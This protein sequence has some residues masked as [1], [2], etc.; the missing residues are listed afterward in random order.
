ML[1]R[2]AQTVTLAKVKGDGR[3]RRR[4]VAGDGHRRGRGF[5][6][7]DADAASRRRPAHQGRRPARDDLR[8]RRRPSGAAPALKVAAR[9]DEQSREE[10]SFARQGTTVVAT[11]ADEA[12]VATIEASPFD[13]VLK[14]TRCR[15][16][17]AGSAGAGHARGPRIAG[18]GA[19]PEKKP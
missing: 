10:V 17:S 16:R 3:E 11:R 15:D 9:F 5:A 7:R 1:T 8:G 14:A 18:P 12:G 2:G 19:T 13:E 4:E 6:A